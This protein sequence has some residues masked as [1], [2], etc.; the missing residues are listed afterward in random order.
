MQAIL[1]TRME[2]KLEE[3]A[4]QADRIFEI[5]N[6]AIVAATAPKTT[7][8][9]QQPSTPRTAAKAQV[10]VLSKQIV[11]LTLQMAKLAEEWSKEKAR[12]RTR[13]G[14]RSR[15]RFRLRNRTPKNDGVC[16]YHKRFGQDFGERKCTHSCTYTEN[17]KGSH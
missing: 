8:P 2:D 3:V 13:S 4:E 10:I 12:N 15:H 5:G 14:S 9:T 6:R 17:D 7:Q 1:A 11:A 16:Y